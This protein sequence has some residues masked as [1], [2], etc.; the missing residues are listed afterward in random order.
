MTCLLVPRLL[1]ICCLAA[2]PNL[3]SAVEAVP[4][5][6]P[7]GDQLVQLMVVTLTPERIV[8]SDTIPGRVAASRR[9]EIRPQVGGILLERRVEEGMRVAVG[10][11]LFRIDPAPL[12]ADLATAE[13]GLARAGAAEAL[14]RSGLE[15]S[16]ALLARNATS[17]EKND[18][19]RNDLAQAQA[20][21]AEAQAILDRRRL[22][23]EFAT[24]RAPIAGHVAAGLADV[25]ALATADADRA[26]AVVQD[27][28]R[29][30][31]DLRL[32]ASRLAAIRAAAL[33][34]PRGIEILI[35]GDR[36]HARPGRLQFSDVNVDPGTGTVS[37]R[38]EVENPGLALM[39]GMY[40]RARLPRGI[41]PEALLVPE[42][43]V[44]RDGTGAAQVVVLSEDG[45][46]VR[47]R[48]TLGD[49]VG[50]RVVVTSGLKSGDVIAIRGQDR[51]AE[52]EPVPA[53][54]RTADALPSSVDP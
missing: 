48:V 26:L 19:A 4:G 41:L 30:H 52:G 22:D 45:Q 40:V 13:A 14:A 9:V 35:E 37:V 31:V 20:N 39:P 34:E 53:A 29:V 43:A 7:A 51:V 27:L 10:D 12:Q 46:A 21:R 3:A 36:P 33:E 49:A 28:D 17:S 2:A 47:R 38:V 25:G 32:P 1:L 5:A 23:L 6:E 18:A 15:R 54:V 44:L 50:P 24:L 11:V 42:D 16:D 8:L